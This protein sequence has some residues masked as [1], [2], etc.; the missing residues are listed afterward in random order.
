MKNY[1]LIIPILFAALFSSQSVEAKMENMNA[2]DFKFRKLHEDE[3]LPLQQFGGKVLLIVNTASHCGFTPQY[4]GLEKLYQTYKDRGLVIVGVPSNDFGG[5]EPGTGEEIAR[6]CRINYGV[7]FPMTEK[8]IVSGD[9]AHPFYV[10][11]RETL[12]F[13]TAP[14]W[15]FHKYLVDRHGKLIDYFHSTT[16][17]DSKNIREA[18]EKALAAK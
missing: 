8:E 9:D 10:W 7:T 11:A 14:K 5:Q 6:F 2:Y 16:S 13:G 17:P 4:D 15:N 1:L 12:G 18:I 3:L